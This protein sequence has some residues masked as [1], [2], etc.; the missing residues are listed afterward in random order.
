E[1]LAGADEA[2]GVIAAALDDDPPAQPG[3]GGDA[4]T[5]RAGFDAEIDRLRTL[6]TDARSALAAL[7]RS[8]RERTGLG[9]L[10]VG[11]HRVFG[12]YL[13][14]PRS[15]AERAPGDY[16]PRQTLASVQRYRYAPLSALETEI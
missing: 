9:S 4:P 15:Q 1:S 13:E 5:V 3:E 14:C 11:Y 10:K 12:Y 8:E 7:E 6:A 16:E 2:A